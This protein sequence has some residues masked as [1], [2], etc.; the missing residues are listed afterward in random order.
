MRQSF[1]LILIVETDSYVDDE[2]L[3]SVLEHSTAAEAIATGLD[4]EHVQLRIDPLQE[5]ADCGD[6]ADLQIDG[7]WYCAACAPEAL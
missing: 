2:R 6:P 3:A 7:T 4:V 5:C 1:A